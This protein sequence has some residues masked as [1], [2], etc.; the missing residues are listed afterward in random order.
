MAHTY[1]VTSATYTPGVPGPDPQVTIVGS[2]DGVAVTV[3]IWLSAI[4]QANL[5]GGLAAVKNLIAPVMLAQMQVN[6]PP[7]PA[8]PVQLPTGT[9][10][11]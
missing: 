9:F 2:V 3:Q 1:V 7:P 10:T 5:A 8:Q 11:Q 4:V 6:S